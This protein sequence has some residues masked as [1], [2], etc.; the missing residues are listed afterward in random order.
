[1]AEAVAEEIR[2]PLQA[3]RE[4]VEQANQKHAGFG[5]EVHTWISSA[6]AETPSLDDIRALFSAAGAGGAPLDALKDVVR[7]A[8]AEGMGQAVSRRIE[9][10]A[11]E[12]VPALAEVIIKK[13]LD[14]LTAEHV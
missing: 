8:V 11:W 6:L 10:V 7:Q 1:M 3:L 5:E 2:P 12:V 13:E 4:A 9:E 14:R